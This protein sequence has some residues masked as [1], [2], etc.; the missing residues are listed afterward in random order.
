[1]HLYLHDY[2]G[3]PFQVDLSRE[4]ARRGWRVTHAYFKDDIGPKGDFVKRSDD[5]EGLSFR[6]QTI[7]RAYS[8]TNLFA[9]R[10]GDIAYGRALAKDIRSVNPDVV[11]SGNTPTEAQEI[12]SSTCW[13]DQRPFV[14]WCQDFYSIATENLLKRKL[15]P[16]GNAIG[17]YY[18]AL[19][20]R[21][22]NRASQIIHI[23][24]DFR[25]TTD[26][27]KIPKEKVSVIEN[28][29]SVAQI[30]VL[31]QTN[32]WTREHRLARVPRV[33]YS[34][35]LG[36]KHDPSLLNAIA[37][38]GL[39]E[40]VVVASGSGVRDLDVS[41]KLRSLPLQPYH[42]MAEV[43]AS[44][45]ILLAMIEP[46]AGAY[47]VPSKILT[48]LCAGRPIVLSAPSTNL[49]A[50]TIAR[51]EAGRVVAP[52]D[53]TAAIAAVRHFL[54]N[55]DAA[56]EAGRNGRTFAEANF[57]IQTIADRFEVVLERALARK[58]AV[59]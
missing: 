24:E 19:E 39:A 55:K 35:T 34:G 52:G 26:Q 21:Q 16:A 53:H 20:K 48:Y 17:A 11:L 1:M 8:K 46:D 37:A 33:L 13:I 31:D 23:T 2:A 4:L 40:V 28:W 15:G 6:P 44:S 50:R 38:S 58:R 49:A 9:R 18:R 29:A 3:H 36:L 42:R 56:N 5:L 7:G 25:L 54:T 41:S 22:M 43:L 30:P 47:S 59:A 45:D 10:S 57:N 27:W 51:N 32:D 12:A 14:F